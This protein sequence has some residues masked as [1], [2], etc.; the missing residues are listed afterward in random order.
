MVTVPGSTVPG[1]PAVTVVVPCRWFSYSAGEEDA[2]GLNDALQFIADVLD[3]VAGLEITITITFYSEDGVLHR[4]NEIAT[5]F[6]SYQ[7]AD[8]TAATAP[9]TVVTG[10]GRWVVAAP[11]NPEILLPGTILEATEP[12]GLPAPDI[13]PATGAAVNLGLWLA[14]EPAG[15]ITARAELGPLWAETT[16][17][18]ASTRFDPGNGDPAVVC[19]SFGTPIP[20]TASDTIEEGPCGYTYTEVPDGDV[21]ITVT[22]T[23]TVTWRTSAGTTG[24]EPDIGVTTALPYDVYEIQTIGTRG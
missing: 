4:W 21:D 2:N 10:D 6:E 23:W 19:N 22:S 24:R 12:I 13:N 3:E 14:V 18:L 1:T 7:I 17:T 11:P 15:P 5:R 8:C 20:P 9:G 16:A